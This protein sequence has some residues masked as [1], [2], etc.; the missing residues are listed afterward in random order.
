MIKVINIGKQAI[1]LDHITINP[2]DN[3]TWLN[4]EIYF[5][6]R[7]KIIKLRSM[8]LI[9]I[10]EYSDLSDLTIEEI[11][12][13]EPIIEEI[14]IEEPEPIIEEKP[15]QTRKRNTKKKSQSKGE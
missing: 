9:Q 15:K 6:L 4:S 5:S 7:R 14:K 10:E 13:E 3:H 1:S 2:R 8:G 11:P 12:T